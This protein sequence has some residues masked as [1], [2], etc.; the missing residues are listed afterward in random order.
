MAQYTKRLIPQGI[1]RIEWIEQIVK[2]AECK[3]AIYC[4]QNNRIFPASALMNQ[5]A[6]TLQKWI[7]NRWLFV[8]NK[9]DDNKWESM[10]QVKGGKQ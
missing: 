9:K 6:A 4:V 8:Y 5:T 2:L 1:N 10:K 3:R 7:N